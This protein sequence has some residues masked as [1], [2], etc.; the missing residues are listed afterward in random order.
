MQVSALISGAKILCFSF[1]E[2]DAVS[3]LTEETANPTKTIPRAIFL[4]TLLGGA[5][6]IITSFF[7]QSLFPDTSRFEHPD[8]ALSEIALYVGGKL[9]QSIFLVT[10]FVNYT[11][12]GHCLTRQRLS[13]FVCDGARRC[14]SK[15]WFGYIYPRWKTPSI[16]VLVVGA[17]SLSGIVF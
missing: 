4:T 9:F 3:T 12:I 7:I 15:K 11:C 6:F 14:V 17:I 13:A 10:T 1:L 8:A 2:F 5:I 16:N